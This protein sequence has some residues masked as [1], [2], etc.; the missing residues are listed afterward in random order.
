MAKLLRIAD[1]AEILGVSADTL[2]R[3]VEDGALQAVRTYGGQLRFREADVLAF[4]EQGQGQDDSN[5]DD[6]TGPA[7]QAKAR[8]P[9][10]PA[11]DKPDWERL[12]PWE[13]KKAEVEAELAIC[14]L[15]AKRRAH[16]QECIR[17]RQAVQNEAADR[18]RLA[19]LKRLGLRYCSHA[20]QRH[21]LVRLLEH[22]VTSKQIPAYL[23]QI[24]QR[25]LVIDRVSRFNSACWEEWGRSLRGK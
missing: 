24:E 25:Q 22:F 3:W 9:R 4:R 2:R 16:K 8:P 7:P 12:P 5:T 21:R 1:A 19:E 11:P 10:K 23:S 13:R 18:E 17:A 20:D 14:D 6:D 15:M